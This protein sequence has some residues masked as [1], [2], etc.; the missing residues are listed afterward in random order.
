MEEKHTGFDAR[1]VEELVEKLDS[2]DFHGACVEAYEEVVDGDKRMA[3]AMYRME[4]GEASV[5]D[6]EV[7]FQTLAGVSVKNRDGTLK[8]LL[9]IFQEAAEK[10]RKQFGG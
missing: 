7:F 1:K 2:Q 6:Y 4:T 10:F 9:D 3:E 8:P 5:D